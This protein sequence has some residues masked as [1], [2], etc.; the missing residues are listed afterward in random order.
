MKKKT[1]K[2]TMGILIA[3]MF[4]IVFS[5]NR[6]EANNWEDW[7]YSFRFNSA[8]T[9]TYVSSEGREKED[10]SKSYILCTDAYEPYVSGDFRFGA[11][12]HG[13]NYLSS[14][15]H[16]CTYHGYGTPSYI[17]REGDS[18]YMTNFV[19]ETYQTYANINVRKIDI[20]AQFY[21][22]WSPDNYNGY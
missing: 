10:T 13:S 6:V 1:F 4:P 16:A 20:A 14:N 7:A 3:I 2:I 15:Y 12:V 8:V 5:A 17:V 21:G 19:K 9:S 22:Y 11:Q 18:Y